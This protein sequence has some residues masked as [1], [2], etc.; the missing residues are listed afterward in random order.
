MRPRSCFCEKVPI[1]WLAKSMLLLYTNFS[2]ID[3]VFCDD[4]E[5]HLSFMMMLSLL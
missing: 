5:C 4:A 1:P 3:P 2:S